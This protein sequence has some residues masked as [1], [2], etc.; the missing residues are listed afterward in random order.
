M[1]SYKRDII[2]GFCKNIIE[3][4]QA[5]VEQEFMLQ[6]NRT[7][8]M[9]KWNNL[10]ET[11]PEHELELILQ[12]YGY[13][14][15]TYVNDKPYIFH[16]S[17]GGTPNEYYLPTLAVI[18]NPY[19]RFSKD[20]KI[21]EDCIVI[22]NDD[23]YN[24][25]VPM[26]NKYASMITEVFISLRLA[27][28]NARVP[29]LIDAD[30]DQ[31]YEDA[32]IFFE[33]IIKGETGVIGH[34]TFFEGIKTYDYASKTTHIKDLLELYQYLKANWFNDIG[35]QANYN[36]KRE[37]L[38]DSELSINEST[39]TPYIDQMLECRKRA[40][41]IINKMY[42][43]NISVELNSSWYNI[44]QDMELERELKISKIKENKES[45]ISPNEENQ[46]KANS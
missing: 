15:F 16:G 3:N 26:F 46:I 36:M 17:L 37:S 2:K 41:D 39:L 4:K 27:T 44:K 40:C 42:N 5:L 14:I 32:K 38:N 30:N 28:I 9:F 8:K 11:I 22:Q 45:E 25:L 29:Y 43:L 20:L 7:L 18:S 6:L 19:L 24:S 13:A 33:N 21:N 34:N 35:L 31:T 1:S 12:M 10:P 23:L